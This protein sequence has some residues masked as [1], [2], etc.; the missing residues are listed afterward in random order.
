MD[1]ILQLI[2]IHILQ[3]MNKILVDS[4]SW[5]DPEEGEQFW[6]IMSDQTGS[7]KYWYDYDINLDMINIQKNL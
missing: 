4:G 3:I 1:S 2:L 6:E 5:I 7:M